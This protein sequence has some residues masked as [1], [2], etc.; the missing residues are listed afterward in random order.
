[1]QKNIETLIYY[2]R[3]YIDYS[4]FGVSIYIYI[5]IY[6]HIQRDEA[7]ISCNK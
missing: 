1:M 3:F 4:I 7:D 6:S 2:N 5:Y